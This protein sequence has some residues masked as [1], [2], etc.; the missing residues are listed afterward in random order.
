MTTGIELPGNSRPV[1]S[2]QS[3]VHEDLVATVEKFRQTDFRK[4]IASFNESA[5]DQA[6]Q[7]YAQHSATQQN[8]A[9]IL[10]SGCGVGE[11]TCHLARQHPRALVLGL[12][13]SADRLSRQRQDQPVNAHF[14]RTDVVDFWRLAAAAGWQPR[15]H[16]LYYPNPYPRKQQLKQR[17]HGHPVFPAL[18]ALGGRLF[19]RSNWLIYLA[20]LQQALLL[21]G[22]ESDI[23]LIRQPASITPFERKYRASGQPVWE[24]TATLTT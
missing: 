19:C 6:Q 3:G 7:L 23:E 2:N 4:P 16:C 12:D 20:E 18:V 21:Y 9:L 22:I 24:L 11:S 14:I 13:R 8:P 17:W 15:K 5:F 10:D 1:S